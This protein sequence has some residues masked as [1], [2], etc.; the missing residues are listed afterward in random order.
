MTSPDTGDQTINSVPMTIS[1]SKHVPIRWNGEQQR[2]LV[3]AGTFNSILVNQFSQAFRTLV[4]LIE[5]DLFTAAYQGASRAYGTAGSSPFGIAGNLSDVAQLRKMLDDNGAPQTDLQLV[6]GSAAVANLRG[7]QTILLKVNESGSAALLRGGSISDVPLEGFALHNS[8]SVSQVVAGNG[9]GF[10]TSGATA[11]GATGVTLASGTGNV[12]VG[13]VVSFAADGANKYVVSAGTSGP[14]VIGL[15]YPG[16][17]VGVPTGNAAS[18][19]AS[20]TPNMGFFALGDAAHHPRPGDA[21]GAGWQV[22]GLGGRHDARDRP[23]FR[24]HLRDRAV[25][26]VPPDG[27][28]RRRGVGA[29]PRSSPAI[30]RPLIG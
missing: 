13:D 27:L 2:G 26:P 3:N 5:N 19:G 16:A 14:G 9:S 10:L 8:N 11:A 1:K 21:D 23:G 20:Y 4:N 17:R 15:A 7:V 18:V 22:A 24:D 28:P 6:L 30:S 29:W 12:L 25:S